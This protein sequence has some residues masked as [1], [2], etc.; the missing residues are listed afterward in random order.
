MGLFSRVKAKV[1]RF[2]DPPCRQIA[3]RGLGRRSAE[4]TARAMI[5]RRAGFSL[6]MLLVAVCSLDATAA[7]K[8]RTREWLEV[9]RGG[10]KGLLAVATEVEGAR[11]RALRYRLDV[12]E[13]HPLHGT[14]LEL[15]RRPATVGK[16]KGTAPVIGTDVVVDV[17]DGRG[18]R[19]G[20]ISSSA[21]GM[22]TWIA[23]KVSDDDRGLFKPVAGLGFPLGLF[24]ALEL[25]PRYDPKVEGEF[26]GTAI[27]RLQPGYTKGAFLEP[28]K[29]G[30]SKQ[31]LCLTVAEIDD[32]KG[33]LRARLL[34]LETSLVDGRV[35]AAR[36]RIRLGDDK[37]ALDW[38]LVDERLDADAGG[39]WGKA[40]LK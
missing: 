9:R 6:A 25:S 19:I 21:E 23:G 12:N 1:A 26:S 4:Q 35:V 29:L 11:F 36:L 10:A 33:A 2:I 31:H 15:R 40:A 14:T 18:K 8:G 32:S 37:P 5:A 20:A 27:V 17:R 16:H 3:R 24:V 38:R 34:W 13:T 39:R 30:V 22:W 28:L 7:P